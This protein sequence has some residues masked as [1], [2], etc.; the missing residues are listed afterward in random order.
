V[1]CC[2]DSMGAAAVVGPRQVS[3]L[4]G[5]MG[6]V[7]RASCTHHSRT[8][9]GNVWFPAM[10]LMMSCA[11]FRSDTKS[12]ARRSDSQARQSRENALINRA[13]LNQLQCDLLQKRNGMQNSNSS[14]KTLV[15]TH[16]CQTS[17]LQSAHV[18]AE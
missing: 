7:H 14:H 18:T 5:I 3:T 1:V 6:S 10:L 9:G 17:S 11:G 13:N 8:P 15:S 2:A 4:G 16:G 12:S